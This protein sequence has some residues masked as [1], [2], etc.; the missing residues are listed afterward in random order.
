MDRILFEIKLRRHFI[1]S[2]SSVHQSCNSSKA[3]LRQIAEPSSSA[4][5]VSFHTPRIVSFYNVINR[6]VCTVEVFWSSFIRFSH[7]LFVSLRVLNIFSFSFV[8]HPILVKYSFGGHLIQWR[9]ES[10]F[11]ISCFN[12]SFIQNLITSFDMIVCKPLVCFKISLIRRGL[13]LWSS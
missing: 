11:H 12:P 13:F 1:Q 4:R 9:V 8:Q 6:I 3:L 2:L 5:V 10:F 7:S